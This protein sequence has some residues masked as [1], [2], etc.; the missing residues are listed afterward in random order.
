MMKNTIFLLLVIFGLFA[1]EDDDSV[2]EP[3]TE[4][5]EIKFT[6][7]A[8]GAMMHYR[9]PNNSDI[10][11]MNIRYKGLARIGCFESLWI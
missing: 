2:F 1:C 7:V 11:A 9:L 5:L 8:G 3:L 10:F 6:P 4:G